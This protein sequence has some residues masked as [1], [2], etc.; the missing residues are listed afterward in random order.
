LGLAA[1][2]VLGWLQLARYHTPVTRGGVDPVLVLAPVAMT[3][4]AALLVLRALPLIARLTDPAARS[5]TGLVLPLGGWQIARRARRHAGPALL[6]TLAL[7]VAAL[8]S[9]ALAVLDR[10]DHDQ[11][12]F[13]L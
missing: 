6:V 8:S 7:A 10:G 3:T 12:V 13:R 5:G 11:A 1:V 9:T 4:A 2:A